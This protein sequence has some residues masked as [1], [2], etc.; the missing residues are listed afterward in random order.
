[1][2]HHPSM[3]NSTAPSTIATRLQCNNIRH[4]G[5]PT[6]H[7]SQPSLRPDISV[8]CWVGSLAYIINCVCTPFG[9][10]LLRRFSSRVICVVGILCCFVSL[11]SSSLMPQLFYLFLTF[12][13]L[14]GLGSG[15]VL[16]SMLDLLLNRFPDNCGRVSFLVFTG[17]TLGNFAW[18]PITTIFIDLWGWRNCLRVTGAIMLLV[19]IPATFLMGVLTTP[20]HPDDAKSS[21]DAKKPDDAMPDTASDK[22]KAKKIRDK[23]EEI[24]WEGPKQKRM[25]WM[26]EAWLF[27]LANL[28]PFISMGFYN[29]NLVSYAISLSYTSNQGSTLVTIAAA[30]E[31]GFKLVFAIFVDKL[32]FR[33]VH[34]M[35]TLSVVSTLVTLTCAFVP[36]FPILCVIGVGIGCVRAT[37]NALPFL[38]GMEIFGVR[39]TSGSTTLV[40]FAEGLGTITSAFIIGGTYDA[41][42]TYDVAIYICTGCFLLTAL[43]YFLIPLISKLHKV[44]GVKVR[45]DEVT[46]VAE[47]VPVVEDEEFMI[48]EFVTVL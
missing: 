4:V 34:L 11:I 45:I 47:I 19:C 46:G 15:L 13:L 6:L 30:A 41:F 27:G 8:C 3:M 22:K 1:M 31:A 10:F 40:L 2:L 43:L 17:S 5:S 21:Q 44:I 42:G 37:M 23:K 24:K 20:S 9:D 36:S 12:G 14:Y 16:K 48:E 18:T 35:T 39:K 26:P 33:K 25:V 28:V 29:V 32:P 7:S 38:L